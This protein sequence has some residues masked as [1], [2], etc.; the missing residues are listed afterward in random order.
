MFDNVIV[1]PWN[2]GQTKD[3]T[4]IGALEISKFVKKYFDFQRYIYISPLHGETNEEYHHKVY[5]ELKQLYGN[6]IVIGGDH[7]IAI[8]SVFSTLHTDEDVCVIWIDAHADINTVNSSVSKNYHGM[9]LSFLTGM[10]QNWKWTTT[11]TKLKFDKLY[12]FGIRDIDHFEME[13]IKK[14]NITVLKDIDEVCKTIER[15]TCVH[16]SF[17]VDAL[18]P[19]DMQSTGTRSDSGIPFNELQE[20][21]TRVLIYHTQGKNINVDICEYNPLIGSSHEKEMSWNNLESILSTLC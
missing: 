14:N 11:L 4:D 16:M 20:L 12:Y 5:S 7:S 15:Y 21:F 17:D 8:G 2:K 18:D 3:G 10:E 13:I 6:K 1:C 19:S 9:P